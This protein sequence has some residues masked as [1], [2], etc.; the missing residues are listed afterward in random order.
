M[1]S[2]SVK[3]SSFRLRVAKPTDVEIIVAGFDLIPRETAEPPFL[4][5]ILAL[6]LAER[7]GSERLLKFGKVFHRQG[8]RLAEGL[9][10]LRKS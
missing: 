10:W 2:G 9:I 4:P 8:P 7:I 3:C 6:R 5:L 1:S